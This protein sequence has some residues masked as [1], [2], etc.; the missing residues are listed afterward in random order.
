[1]KAI[2]AISVYFFSFYSIFTESSSADLIVDFD[3]NST[4]EGNG[5]ATSSP[6]FCSGGTCV[7]EYTDKHGNAIKQKQTC[8]KPAGLIC[9]QNESCTCQCQPISGSVSSSNVCV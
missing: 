3:L 8:K 5:V 7:L 1:M 6:F 2:L 9:K 4:S